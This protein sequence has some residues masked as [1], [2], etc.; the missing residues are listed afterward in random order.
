MTPVASFSANRDRHL[1]DLEALCRI[2]SVSALDAANVRKSADAV[3]ALL[4]RT[5]LNNVQ[6]LE[7]RDAHPSVYADWIGDDR[8]PTL[9]IYGHHD[10]QPPG[11][12]ERWSSPPFEPEVRDGRLYARGSSDDKGGVMACRAM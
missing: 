3:A 11:N 2:P 6:L 12:I 4:R 1:R 9:L 7:P 8:L 5:G 10:V